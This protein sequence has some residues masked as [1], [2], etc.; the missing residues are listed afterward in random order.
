MSDSSQRTA[1]QARQ[2]GQALNRHKSR[3]VVVIRVFLHA[4]SMHV[5]LLLLL[6][7]NCADIFCACVQNLSFA[8][9]FL[10]RMI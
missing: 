9:Q 8:I 4:H 10:R 3:I 2:L 6:H 7:V 5:F 1:R